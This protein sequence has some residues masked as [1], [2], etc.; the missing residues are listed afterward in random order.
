MS[1]S[2]GFW[3][4]PIADPGAERVFSQAVYQR[5]AMTLQA[6]RNRIGEETFWLLIRT[7][8]AEQAGGNATSE[9]FEALAER[10]SGQDLKSFFTAWLRA[11]QKPARTAAN[12]L[13]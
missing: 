4:V 8:L 5:G 10:I 3:R 9:E 13:G 12:G 11:P 2:T 7:W 6:L 1:V